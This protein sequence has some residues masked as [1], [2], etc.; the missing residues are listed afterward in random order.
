MDTIAKTTILLL[1]SLL[2]SC[3]GAID[4][5]RDL[6]EKKISKYFFPSSDLD[7][8]LVYVYKNKSI[9][10]ESLEYCHLKKDSNSL[11]I[12]LFDENFNLTARIKDSLSINGVYL[13]S[14]VTYIND[15]PC[16]FKSFNPL[17]FPSLSTTVIEYKSS[18]VV[19]SETINY[20]IKMKY[21]GDSILTFGKNNF[22]CIYFKSK[23]K[24]SNH[25]ED[26]LIYYA[27]DIGLI[28]EE[29]IGE[30]KGI[31]KKLLSILTN[32]EFQQLKH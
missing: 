4:V 9:N 20:K 27:E 19:E 25:T 12:E 15:S 8:G 22:N 28:K 10:N 18:L 2:L 11:F 5:E 17:I 14:Y 6:P 16:Y 32:E 13:S 26:M 7:S 24:T 23:I 29:T 3:T 1:F 30:S 31:K 21:A